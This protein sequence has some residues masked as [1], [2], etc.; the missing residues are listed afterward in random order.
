VRFWRG[1][2]FEAAAP[3]SVR[4]ELIALDWQARPDGR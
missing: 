4:C 3:P 1:N 2:V